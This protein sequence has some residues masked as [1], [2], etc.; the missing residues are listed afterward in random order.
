MTI[1]RADPGVPPAVVGSLGAAG[2]TYADTAPGS[3]AVYQVYSA[4][5][6]A[7]GPQLDVTVNRQACKQPPPPKCLHTCQ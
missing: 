7:C 6:V 3:T 1:L 4:D 5:G 2:G